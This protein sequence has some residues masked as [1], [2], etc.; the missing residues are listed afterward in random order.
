MRLFPILISVLFL[1]APVLARKSRKPTIAQKA[2][3]PDAYGIFAVSA[4]QLIELPALDWKAPKLQAPVQ[5]VYYSRSLLVDQESWS[6]L[7]TSG[8]HTGHN[9]TV[10]VRPVPNHRDMVGIEIADELAAG[11]TYGIS[12]DGQVIGTFAIAP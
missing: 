8:Q 10:R 9:L 5:I 1:S 12:R 3:L 11:D 7:V 2:P 4:G 6:C